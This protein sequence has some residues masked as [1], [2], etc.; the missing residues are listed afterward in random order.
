MTEQER[1]AIKEALNEILVAG[2][3]LQ[4]YENLLNKIIELREP[5]E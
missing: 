2:D 4:A 1:I 5:N 3:E